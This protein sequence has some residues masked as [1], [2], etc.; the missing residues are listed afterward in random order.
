MVDNAVFKIRDVAVRV[1]RNKRSI[2]RWE[3]LGK[4]PPARRTEA[5][6]RIYSE[7]DIQTILNFMKKDTFY[8]RRPRK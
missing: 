7:E 8:R 6:D 1:N 5:N 2:I 3:Q 4:I